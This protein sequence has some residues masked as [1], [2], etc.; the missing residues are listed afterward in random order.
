M[1]DRNNEEKK[2]F[3]SAGASLVC[4]LERVGNLKGSQP[5]RRP[6]GNGCHMLY[7]VDFGILL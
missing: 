7:L 1:H 6:A 3:C 4:A 2:E 5:N